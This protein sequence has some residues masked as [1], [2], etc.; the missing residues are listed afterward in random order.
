MAITI[1]TQPQQLTPAYNPIEFTFSGNNYSLT[2]YRYIVDVYNTN[3]GVR[4]SRQPIAPQPDG[5]GKVDISRII[6]NHLDIDFTGTTNSIAN[7]INT[8]FNYTIKIGETYKGLNWPFTGSTAEGFTQLKMT[9]SPSNLNTFVVGDQIIIDT[10]GAFDGLFTVKSP[11]TDTSIIIDSPGIVI[12]SDS[13]TVNYADGRKVIVSDIN[14]VSGFTAFNGVKSFDDFITWSGSGYTLTSSSTTKSLLT[15]LPS[16]FYATKEQDIWLNAYIAKST[17][18]AYQ[19]YSVTNLGTSFYSYNITGATTGVS[20]FNIGYDNIFLFPPA[21]PYTYYDNYIVRVSGAT[22]QII[23]KPYRVNVDNR[24]KINNFEVAF[25]D[26]MGSIGSFAFQLRSKETGEI[27]RTQYKAQVP[28]NYTTESRGT[29]NIFIGV[30]KSYEFNT[31]WMTDEMSV[32]FEE[33][34]E[35][36]YQWVKLDD[37]KYHACVVKETSFETERQKNQKLIRKT[38]TITLANNSGVN[39]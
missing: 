15:N 18:W 5:T 34:L 11:R 8:Y 35:S 10:T 28:S 30:E 27:T 2:G 32:Y 14:V 29:R 37:G 3:T 23:S 6:A 38:V 17:G 24:C 12:G 7:A 33:L 26:R 36:P 1:L 19:I 22:T 13:G 21:T 20:Q 4:I 39:I 31:N 16:N 9:S 25:M